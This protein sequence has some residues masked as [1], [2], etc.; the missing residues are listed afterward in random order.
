MLQLQSSLLHIAPRKRT[1][2]IT[3]REE[4]H[5]S[6]FEE[7]FTTTREEPKC[8][9]KEDTPATTREDESPLPKLERSLQ[10]TTREELKHHK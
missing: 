6:R 5:P 1:L 2:H 3:T 7:F 8:T 10:V 4:P 9:T